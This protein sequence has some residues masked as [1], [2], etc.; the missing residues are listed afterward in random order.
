MQQ[1]KGF[2]HGDALME[3]YFPLVLPTPQLGKLLL[4][5]LKVAKRCKHLICIIDY[6]QV[7]V[8][9]AAGV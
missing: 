8:T 2:W 5:V 9:D 6:M 3:A 4:A 1:R 7:I